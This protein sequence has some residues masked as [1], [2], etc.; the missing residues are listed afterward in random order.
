MDQKWAWPNLRPLPN[1]LDSE[2]FF[3]VSRPLGQQLGEGI[4]L[5]GCSSK[6][7]HI[8]EIF[9]WTNSDNDWMIYSSDFHLSDVA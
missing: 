6:F 5:F 4:Q 3:G 9:P 7:V 1:E 2:L 8:L